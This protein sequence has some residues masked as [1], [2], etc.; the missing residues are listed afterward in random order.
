[1]FGPGLWR[2]VAPRGGGG[3]VDFGSDLRSGGSELATA[4]PFDAALRDVLDRL[5]ASTREL[6]RHPRL[7]ELGERAV[8]I[9]LGLTGSSEAVLAIDSSGDGYRRVFS[10]AAGRARPMREEDATRLLVSPGIS[11][12]LHAG[13]ANLGSLA[14]GRSTPFSDADRLALAIFASD[15]AH[16]VEAA[17]LRGHREGAAERARAQERAVEVLSAVSSLAAAGQTL[18][19]F[20]R[21]L[22]Q[23]V[24]QLVEAKRVLFWRLN[25]EQML[26]PA[27]GFGVDG[28]FVGR[29]TPIRAHPDDDDLASKVVHKDLMFRANSTVEFADYAYVLKR[30]GVKSAIS[31][32]WRAGDNRLGLVAAYDST[33]PGAFSPDDMWMLLTAGHA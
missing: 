33:R 10:R 23:T 32:P 19:D 21:R 28:S 18:A 25:E 5:H 12:P 4:S 24:A 30:L 3:P 14:V 2:G 27:G 22:A 6:G 8:E 26:S 7:P 29:L 20:Y 15:V 13:D 1:M 16:A 17:L 31:V 9:A 11:A